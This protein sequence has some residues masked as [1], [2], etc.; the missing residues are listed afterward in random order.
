MRSCKVGKKSNTPPPP[1]KSI[2]AY[3]IEIHGKQH[4]GC[5][6]RQMNPKLGQWQTSPDALQ[7]TSKVN[8]QEQIVQSE[9]YC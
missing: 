1:E 6:V 8:S 3:I 9:N 4:G 5:E 7:K 2:Q